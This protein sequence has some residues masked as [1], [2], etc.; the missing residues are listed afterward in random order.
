MYLSDVFKFT[1]GLGQKGHQI[2]RKVGDAIELLTLGIIHLDEN[3]TKYLEIEDGVEGATSAKHKVEFS[4][5][6]LNENGVP[7]KISEQLFGIIEC[8]KVGVEQTIKQNFK[9]WKS[10]AANRVAFH[11]TNGYDFTISPNATEYK[12][13]IKIT[14]EIQGNNNLKISIDKIEDGEIINNETKYYSCT[15][16]QQLLIA[17]DDNNDL[18]L[19]G[20]NDKLSQ[21]QGHISKCIVVE[22][23]NLNNNFISDINVNESLPG[24]QTPEKAKQASFVSLDV[25]KKVLG[26]FDKT[27]DKSFISILVIGEASHWE[28][29]SRSM[30][31][32]CNDYNL[33][34]PDEILVYL[35]EKF[36]EK[37]GNNYQEKITKTNYRILEDVR[38]LVSEIIE[39][40]DK[41][42]LFDMA[43]NNFVIFSHELENNSNRLKVLEL[44]N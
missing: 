6:H 19:L 10:V 14:G 31:R 34:I 18:F 25:R 16:D 38:G 37:F 8:K 7:S 40:F 13:A 12:W 36:E 42:V 43:T 15:K 22:I 32:L 1:Q 23:K 33:I 2:G 35:F 29:K 26:H 4:F 28:E 39:K 21:V 5:Y 20:P 17:V 30:V 27:T 24:P 3:L 9:Q 41:K 44:G 11:L